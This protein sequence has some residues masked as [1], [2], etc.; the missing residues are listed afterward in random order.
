MTSEEAAE[1]ADEGRCVNPGLKTGSDSDDDA[2]A[3]C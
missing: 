3:D 1:Q 2:A